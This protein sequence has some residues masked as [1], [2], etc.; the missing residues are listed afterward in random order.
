V[1]GHPRLRLDVRLLMTSDVSNMP[2]KVS[3]YCVS[4]TDKDMIGGTKKKSKAA[5]LRNDS[6]T[7]GPR[8]SRAVVNTTPSRYSITRLARSK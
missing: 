8:P 5:T 7:P 3:R 6:S 1:T 4:E 2:T